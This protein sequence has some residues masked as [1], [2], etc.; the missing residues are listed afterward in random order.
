MLL[1]MLTMMM[2]KMMMMMMKMKMMRR[3]MMMMVV[4]VVV[5]TCRVGQ[6][7]GYEPQD[8]IEKTLYQHIHAC[9]VL[10]MR[11]SHHIRT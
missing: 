6:L 4:V 5:V 10:H 2:M 11:F 8:L 1:L 3:R 7:T 9:D